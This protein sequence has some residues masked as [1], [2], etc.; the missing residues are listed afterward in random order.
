[1]LSNIA[2]GNSFFWMPSS[3]KTYCWIKVKNKPQN[4]DAIFSECPEGN[5]WDT[6]HQNPVRYF[7]GIDLAC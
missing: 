1:M 7:L 2:G 5:T 3:E 4:E 6:W